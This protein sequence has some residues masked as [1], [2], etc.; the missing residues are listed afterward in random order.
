MRDPRFLGD[1]LLRRGLVTE[2]RMET[3]YATQKEKG[4]DIIDHIVA[5]RLAEETAIAR[6]LAEEAER[7]YVET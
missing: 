4:G 1:L 5:A 6:A 7:P 2:D 3:L